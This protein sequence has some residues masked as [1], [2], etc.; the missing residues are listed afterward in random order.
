MKLNPNAMFAHSS[1]F[2]KDLFCFMC[3]WHFQCGFSSCGEQTQQWTKLS[4]L[5]NK[6]R[7]S[8]VCGGGPGYFYPPNSAHHLS[9]SFAKKN[10]F[11]TL[12]PSDKIV[13]I[14]PCKLQL[15]QSMG[16]TRKRMVVID[17][18]KLH[19]WTPDSLPPQSTN[20]AI[21]VMVKNAPRVM[22]FILTSLANCPWRPPADTKPDQHAFT[23]KLA[24]LDNCKDQA[25]PTSHS[26]QGKQCKIV[27]AS[28]GRE[29]AFS[30]LWW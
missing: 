9:K 20:K 21:I 1:G 15:I 7:E 19:S 5:N 4:Y 25:C 3:W 24:N 27:W 17:G 22:Q 16:L 6:A 28:D 26:L 18:K 12:L 30:F 13:T 23:C 14:P 10:H 2:Y 8:L 11:K 29:V